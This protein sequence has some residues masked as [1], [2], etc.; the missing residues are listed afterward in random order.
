MS[1]ELDP[2]ARFARI[3]SEQLHNVHPP[4]LF[5]VTEA[6][7][8]KMSFVDCIRRY[9]AD[10]EFGRTTPPDELVP[11]IQRIHAGL[12]K[13]LTFKEFAELVGRDI[14]QKRYTGL[15]KW[16]DARARVVR[17]YVVELSAWLAKDILFFQKKRLLAIWKEK[18]RDWTVT[19]Q[20]S[21]LKRLRHV[22]GGFVERSGKLQF[23]HEARKIIERAMWNSDLRFFMKLGRELEEV[24]KK[25]RIRA[26]AKIQQGPERSSF[27]TAETLIKKWSTFDRL[28]A[29]FCFAESVLRRHH[30]IPG[31]CHFSDAALNDFC[32][33]VIPECQS[34]AA[35]IR[36]RLHLVQY[37]PKKPL[38]T[39]VIPPLVASPKST[40]PSWL[41]D[42][43]KLTAGN[44]T[45]LR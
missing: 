43:A 37:S 44:K 36:E 1:N 7:L 38:V 4:T 19:A 23:T 14:A 18:D 42:V 39:Q 31:L 15:S 40:A 10:W 27:L 41:H 26:M 28:P 29:D 24:T 33:I 11:V 20:K 17:D 2:E 32:S 22:G 45:V 34:D 30:C 9:W 35:K 3:I 16:P 8:S 6:R 5:P 21:L 13:G 12:K 25:G